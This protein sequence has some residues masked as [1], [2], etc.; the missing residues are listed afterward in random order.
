MHLGH[1]STLQFYLRGC[2]TFQWKLCV[3]N[4]LPCSPVNVPHISGKLGAFVTLNIS[5]KQFV[6]KLEA[7]P[8]VSTGWPP[9]CCR[10]ATVFEDG[11]VITKVLK[12]S[13]ICK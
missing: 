4:R 13:L 12:S 1:Q 3:F 8:P 5:V 10:V 6:A 11:P 9:K 2:V 7:L